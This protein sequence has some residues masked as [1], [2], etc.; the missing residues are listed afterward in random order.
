M[1][2]EKKKQKKDTQII[3]KENQI[4]RT[5]NKEIKHTEIRRTWMK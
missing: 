3:N 2:E 1:N 4:K 5:K